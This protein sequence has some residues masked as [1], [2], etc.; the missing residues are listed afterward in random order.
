MT[1][2]DA[3]FVKYNSSGA[4]QWLRKYDNGESSFVPEEKEDTGAAMAIDDSD[5]LYTIVHQKYSGKNVIVKQDT[6]G[7]ILWQRSFK[8][9]YTGVRGLT[10]TI[11]DESQEDPRPFKTGLAQLLPIPLASIDRCK[12]T[13]IS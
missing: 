8:L 5:N 3:L 9:Q 6:S 11:G 2:S 1:E 12:L 13:L 4:L 10:H 7:N